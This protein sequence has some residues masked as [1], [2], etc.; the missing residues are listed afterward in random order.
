LVR[1]LVA[2]DS[3]KESLDA[4]AV[5]QAIGRGIAA[6]RPGA[7][8]D[9][10]PMADGG[11]GTVQA[12]VAATDG[13]MRC[14]TVKGPL[15]D[16]V[17]AHWGILGDGDTAV[18]EMAEAAG[19]HRLTVC[20]RDP[21]RATT[22]GVGQLILAALE[23]GCRRIILGIGGSATSDGGAGMAQALGVRLLCGDGQPVP[24]G[25]GGGMLVDVEQIDTRNIDPRLGETEITVA[26]DVTNPLTGPN[27]AAQVYGPQKGA[28]PLQVAHLDRS[29]AHWAALINRQAHDGVPGLVAADPELPG[30]GAAGGLGFGLVAFCNAT[31]D[32]GIELVMDAVQF[33]QR[34]RGADL[35][36]TGEGRLDGQSILGKTCLGVARRAER[37]GVPTIALVGSTG[38]DVQKTL[39]HGLS[40]YYSLVDLAGS[41]ERA[42][43]ETASLLEKLARQVVD[44]WDDG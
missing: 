6:A 33:D 20:R 38:P 32:R 21:T 34:V 39:E 4:P 19:L 30:A 14:A 27:G 40:A 2:P 25:S 35:V 44:G 31:L 12:L 16:P 41:V 7:V 18:I 36:I 23:A 22:F 1:Y 24:E 26:C 43:Q 29:L 10:C 9:H 15:G 37:A 28:L 11:E 3:F 5:A 8:I 42:M 13:Q 17:E